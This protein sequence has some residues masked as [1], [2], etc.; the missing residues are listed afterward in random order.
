MWK[1]L[2]IAGAGYV[3]GKRANF[4]VFMVAL[5]LVAKNP[6]TAEL[7]EALRILCR[8][9]NSVSRLVRFRSGAAIPNTECHN[10]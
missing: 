6:T 10:Q 5:A 3:T 1:S 7:L 8:V 9:R 2:L 4:A